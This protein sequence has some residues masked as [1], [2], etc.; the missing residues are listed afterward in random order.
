M[1]Y[2]IISFIFFNKSIGSYLTKLE[3]RVPYNS[4][5]F[6][7]IYNINDYD[8]KIIRDKFDNP[9]LHKF[10]LALKINS[11][12]KIIKLKLMII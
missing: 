10:Q 3:N 2:K 12:V 6:A 4:K 5:G 8:N 1:N 7:Y 9:E 11:L